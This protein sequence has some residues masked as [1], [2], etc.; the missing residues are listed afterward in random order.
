MPYYVS[1][2]ILGKIDLVVTCLAPLNSENCCET[3]HRGEAR[4]NE[5]EKWVCRGCVLFSLFSRLLNGALRFLPYTFK[6]NGHRKAWGRQV[7][8]P[9][10]SVSKKR[11]SR[12]F[13][14]GCMAEGARCRR[15]KLQIA[16]IRASANG[17]SFRCSSSPTKTTVFVG[18]HEKSPLPP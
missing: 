4:E 6:E 2:M 11:Q 16:P 12:F 1:K 17:R 14:K 8:Y 13:E 9:M 18:P 5:R 15:H 3:M 10:F 7:A